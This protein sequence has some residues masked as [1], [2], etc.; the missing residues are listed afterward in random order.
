MVSYPL[1]IDGV[2]SF[3]YTM[4]EALSLPEL[5]RRHLPTRWPGSNGGMMAVPLFTTAVGWL[6]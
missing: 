4:Q 3:I 5:K 6:V 2:G 1:V